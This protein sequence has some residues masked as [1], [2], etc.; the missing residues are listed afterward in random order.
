MKV[1][2]EDNHLLVV[3]KPAG[4]LTQP[5]DSGRP[6]IETQAKR[7]IKEKYAKPGAVFLHA[8]HRLDRPVAGIV[9]IAKTS[10]ALSRLNE[11]LREGKWQRHYR[12]WLSGEISVDST[13]EHYLLR[14]DEG[15]SVVDKQVPG[16]KLS[17]LQLKSIKSE[18]GCTLVQIEL[19]TG[20][21]HQIRLQLSANK[22]PILGDGRYGS[23]VAHDT[24]ALEHYQL[25]FPH[26]T[27]HRDVQIELGPH[28]PLPAWA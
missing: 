9:V 15:S 25:K 20:R 23:S 2:Y 1:L 24:I 27:L 10:K 17:R 18:K 19:D 26:P 16:A 8:A 12:A 7:Y 14:T 3:E 28:F 11:T 4:M 21:H 22:T 13:L 5:D 6:D